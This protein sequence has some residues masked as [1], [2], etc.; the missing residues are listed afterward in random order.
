MRGSRVRVTQAAPALLAQSLTAALPRG[1]LEKRFVVPDAT[2]TYRHQLLT[3]AQ[4]KMEPLPRHQCLVY[5]GPPLAHLAS[6]ADVVRKKLQ[7]NI[8]CLYLN[9]PLM[10]AKMCTFLTERGVDVF[11]QTEKGNLVLSSDQS[12]LIDGHFDVDSMIGALEEAVRQAKRDRCQ[13]LWATGDMSWEFGSK[14]DYATLLEYER[15][16]E[17]LFFKYPSLSGV[18]QYH[19][20]SLP[21]DVVRKGLTAHKAIFINETLSQ[22]NP[23]YEAI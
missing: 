16:L 1:Y 21:D 4:K 13:G 20:E 2:S 7:E 14:K 10:V 15:R 19:Q 23:L 11:D 9:S 3:W 12:H 6:I 18:C 8:R 22:L 5:G 17:H